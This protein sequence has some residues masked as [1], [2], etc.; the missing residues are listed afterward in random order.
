M[1]RIP[2]CAALATPAA[3]ALAIYTTF[4]DENDLQLTTPHPKQRLKSKSQ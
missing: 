4:P 3:D 1:S 2:R